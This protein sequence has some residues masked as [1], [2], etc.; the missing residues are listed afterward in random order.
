MN[1]TGCNVADFVGIRKLE[2]RKNNER[3]NQTKQKENTH[4]AQME[5]SLQFLNQ[6][7]KL[8]FFKTKVLDKVEEM[9]ARVHVIGTQAYD[10][11]AI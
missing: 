8:S 4:P 6:H 3:Q 7:S 1:V 5:T 9:P 11:P 2:I 10:C